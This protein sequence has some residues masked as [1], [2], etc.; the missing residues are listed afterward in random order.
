MRDNA[1]FSVIAALAV[2]TRLDSALL[3]FPAAL[4]RGASIVRRQRPPLP[5]R[6]TALRIAAFVVPGATLLGV[7]LAWKL[8][9]YGAVLPNTFTAKR[10]DELF[11]ERGFYYLGVFFISYL[12]AP[13]LM[14]GPI[15]FVRAIRERNFAVVSIVVAITLWG[16]YV[17]W[18]GGDFMEFRFVVPALPLGI[19][20]L[21]WTIIRLAANRFI[22]SAAFA[23]VPIGSLHH[24]LTF[25]ADANPADRVDRVIE[26]V[27]IL[28]SHIDQNDGN[29]PGI[30]RLLGRT[31][32]GQRDVS[33]A[34]TAAGAIP[35]Y[36]KMRAIDMHGLTDRTV[37]LHGI[38]TRGNVGHRRVAP[39]SYLIGRK[40]NLVFGH[41]WLVPNR[42]TRPSEAQVWVPAFGKR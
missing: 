23:L 14:V 17:V 21:V 25:G 28:N 9:T 11:V 3:L 31:F 12:L 16:A 29:W 40:V 26:S 15:A 37:A 39:L 35:F 4:F 1:L 5:A 34:T 8:A 18:V 36:A 2:L 7:W 19:V 22:R 10:P 42:A 32:A 33:I 27:G 20:A 13:F 30:G 24:A 38:P 41:P 6:T